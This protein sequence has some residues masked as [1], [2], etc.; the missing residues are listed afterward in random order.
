MKTTICECKV[1]NKNFERPTKEV[2]RS[3]KIGRPNYCSRRCAGL[4]N[5]E[6]GKKNLGKEL[7]NGER[8]KLYAGSKKDE[9][10]P[11]K[12]FLRS[13][14]QRFKQIDIDLQHLK[15]IW[16]KQQGKCPFTGWDLSLERNNLPHQASLDR[17]DSNKGYVKGNVRFI[18]LIANYCKNNF[19][20]EEVLKFCNSVAIKS[21]TA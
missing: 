15:E 19:T 20:D 12:Q 13:A 21:Q 7:G 1:C 2:D 16:E 17:I 4:G 14:K 6:I 8:I 18:A 11:Y 9:Y 10:T 5:K 3:K